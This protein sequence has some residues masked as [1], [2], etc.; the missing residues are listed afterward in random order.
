MYKKTKINLGS[1][2]FFTYT[3]LWQVAIIFA[4]I[5]RADFVL[6]VSLRSL[7]WLSTKP[8]FNSLEQNCYTFL[9][10]FFNE[11]SIIFQLSRI[12]FI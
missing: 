1:V 9:T 10:F 5:S 11:S 4:I 2:K 8:W 12:I 7:L 3:I 6:S